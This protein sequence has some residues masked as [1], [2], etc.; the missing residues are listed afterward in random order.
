MV[1]D[2][3]MNDVRERSPLHELGERE[4]GGPLFEASGSS[5]RDIRDREMFKLRLRQS[6]KAVKGPLV[7]RHPVKAGVVH[8]TQ[9]PGPSSRFYDGGTI[10]EGDAS[11]QSCKRNMDVTEKSPTSGRKHSSSSQGASSQFVPQR[12]SRL[13]VVA[14]YNPGKGESMSPGQQ[15]KSTQGQSGSRKTTPPVLHHAGE[16]DQ[17]MTAQGGKYTRKN[18]MSP[19]CGAAQMQM[20]KRG[21]SPTAGTSFNGM[22]RSA[23]PSRN[24]KRITS[25]KRGDVS[26][27][28]P[29]PVLVTRRRSPS[30][31]RNKPPSPGGTI[32]GSRPPSPRRRNPSPSQLDPEQADA[33]RKRLGKARKVKLYLMH[34]IG[35]NSFLVA[36]EAPHQKYKVNIGPQTCS[37]GKSPGCLHLLFIMLRVFKIQENDTRLT[38]RELKEFEIEALFRS[39]EERKK[40][41]VMRSRQQSMENLD[42]DMESLKGTIEEVPEED[43]LCPICLTEMLVDEDLNACSCC[44]NEVHHH[45]MARWTEE[46]QNQ[47]DVVCPLCRSSWVP[48]SFHPHGATSTQCPSIHSKQPH[49]QCSGGFIQ[50]PNSAQSSYG[51]NITNKHRN[52]CQQ[53]SNSSVS[54]SSGYSTVSRTSDT[55]HMIEQGGCPEDIP[56]PKAEPILQQHWPFASNW[57]PSFGR[58]LVACLFSRDWVKRETG[59]RRLAREIVK[60]LQQAIP[61]SHQN[62]MESYS[63]KVEKS[64]KICADMLSMMIEDKVYKVYLAAVKTLRALLQFINCDNETQLGQI[65]AHIRPI[66]QSVL[67]KCADSNKRISEVSTESLF[68]LCRGQL[69][70]MALGIHGQCVLPGGLGGVDYILQI[71]L[72]DRD[73]HSVSWQWLMGRLVLLEKIMKELPEEF[74]LENQQA[75]TNFK[76]LMMIIDF[77]YQNLASS[78]ANVSKLAR[79]VFILAARNTA[80]DTTTFNQVWDLMGTLDPGLQI[81]M[82]KRLAVAIEEADHG[83]EHHSDSSS[84]GSDVKGGLRSPQEKDRTAFLEQFLNEC[85]NQHTE[86]NHQNFVNSTMIK[87]K[88]WRPPLM[89]STSHSPSRQIAQS[90]SN[91]QSPS[92]AMGVP[93]FKKS[94]CQSVLNVNQPTC[95]VKPRIQASNKP[96]VLQN[97]FSS[98]SKIQEIASEILPKFDLSFLESEMYGMENESVNERMDFGQGRQIPSE[99]ENKVNSITKSK[100]MSRVASQNP[101]NSSPLKAPTTSSV[102][103]QNPM[104]ISSP[105]QKKRHNGGIASNEGSTT[106]S[107]QATPV[108]SPKLTQRDKSHQQGSAAQLLHP[109][110]CKDAVDYEESLA[111][112]MALSKSIYLETPLPVIPGLSSQKS[113]QDVIAH[114]HR[115]MMEDGHQKRSY[116]EGKDWTK[117]TVLGTGAY[118]TCYQARDVETGTLMAAKQ[119]SFCRNSDE[120]QD[121]VEDLI[122]EEVL[123]IS[124]LQHPHVV[125]MYGAIQDEAH[126]NVFVEWMPGGSIASLLEKHGA[127]TEAVSLRNMHQVLLGLDYLHSN[128]ILHR[129]LKGANLLVDTSGHHLR[130]A[131]FGAAARMMSKTTVPGEFR[132]QLTGTIAF[133]AP[134]VLRGDSYGRTCDIWSVG[135]CIIEM[136]TGKPPWGASDVSNHLALIFRIACAAEPPPVPENLSPALRDLTRRCLELDPSLRP[137]ARDLLLHP[138]FHQL[139]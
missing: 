34:Q 139:Q 8:K 10:L 14:M 93:Q 109:A 98:K 117:G 125:R 11:P 37:C 20:S 27:R 114:P 7:G 82:R 126:I 28:V 115:D 74:S 83:L 79:K 97:R 43:A 46:C 58:D 120:E 35:S 113:C 87:K 101:R 94:L 130:I 81:R 70:Q 24:G 62:G 15:V 131:D 32:R 55:V 44:H 100:S 91:S 108:S 60:I 119:I 85:S 33:L 45:C 77:S 76:R 106:Y 4:D 36:G 48:L 133:M 17:K 61:G 67:V 89:R 42:T 102:N 128:G 1:V 90:R 47:G 22:K 84:L 75:H 138:V 103:Q 6:G 112:A 127:F 29:S 16:M 111:L 99:I 59:L 52:P 124:K 135:C 134:E 64:W 69:G 51:P 71:V 73:F 30:L 38:A 121:K 49:S 19:V 78:H 18:S 116:R 80:A 105:S 68:E 123:L 2:S 21:M 53:N 95:G 12:P 92:R 96:R 104:L 88:G 40:T 86:F 39:Y 56:L 5:E 136:A 110:S 41:R 13:P 50:H 107:R 63:E 66:I 31:T 122:R 3:G 132:G 23:S 129:D 57:I 137:T 25:P 118:S 72:E 54:N 9:S 26:R 65:R